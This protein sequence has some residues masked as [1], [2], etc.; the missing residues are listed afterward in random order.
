MTQYVTYSW[1]RVTI[2]ALV[3][4][5]SAWM[6]GFDFRPVHLKIVV[7]KVTLDTFICRYYGFCGPGTVVG[8]ATAYGFD[9][10]GIE[11]RWGRRHSAPVQT[12]PEAHPTSCT[13]GTVS[14][15]GVRCG[16]GVRLTPRPLLVPRSKIE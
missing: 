12:G 16:R 2:R 6:P 4:G 10:P 15:P 11:S 8:I 9:G 7:D 5:F 14:F 13:M 3:S 1:I